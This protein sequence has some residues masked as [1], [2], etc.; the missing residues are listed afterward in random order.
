MS[1]SQFDVSNDICKETN[2]L[3]RA[4]LDFERAKRGE[5]LKRWCIEQVASRNDVHDIVAEASKLYR[6]L[7]DQEKAAAG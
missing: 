7:R 5:D 3:K 6:W 2:E 1:I 4:E